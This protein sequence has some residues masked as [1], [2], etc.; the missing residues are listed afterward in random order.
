[1]N[2]YCEGVENLLITVFYIGAGAGKKPDRLRNTGS[3]CSHVQQLFFTRGNR[4][5]VRIIYFIFHRGQYYREDGHTAEGGG[6]AELVASHARP[7]QEACRP[8]G[9]RLLMRRHGHRILPLRLQE[10]HPTD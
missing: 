4:F 3:V 9:P 2:F 5:F 1:M 7:Q 6:E 8:P 10:A